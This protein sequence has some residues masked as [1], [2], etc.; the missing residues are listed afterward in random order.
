MHDSNFPIAFH[1][2]V[3]FSSRPE[4][5]GLPVLRTWQSRS[6]KGLFDQGE[7][8]FPCVKDACDSQRHLSRGRCGA[9]LLLHS[10]VRPIAATPIMFINIFFLFTIQL[11]G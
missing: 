1:D 7:V 10:L 6:K 3:S 2:V 8:A 5:T 11:L 4:S 9:I